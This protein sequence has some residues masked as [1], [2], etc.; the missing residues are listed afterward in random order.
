M[1]AFSKQGTYKMVTDCV[2]SSSVDLKQACIDEVER[3]K[4]T[5]DALFAEAR[6]LGKVRKQNQA[7]YDYFKEQC[8]SASR[9]KSE[10]QLIAL[11]ESA[12]NRGH[13]RIKRHMR[14]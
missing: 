6:G 14:G 10:R 9:R 11:I 4:L 3:D 12:E 7:Q 1:N 5:F 13:R 2:V 8:T